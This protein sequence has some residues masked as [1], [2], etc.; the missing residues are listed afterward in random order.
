MAGAL[1]L[2]SG[3]FVP[4]VLAA[5]PLPETGR[6]LIS[7]EGDISLPA[8]EHADVVVVV[9]G[10]ADIRGEVNTLVVVQGTATLTGARLETV[11]AVRSE[12]E[13]A[14]GTVVY[15]ELQRLD[16][17]VHQTGNPQLQGGIVDLSARL[18]DVGR[19]VGPA[20]LM[21]WF[22]FALSTIVAGLLLAGLAARHVRAAEQLISREP[23]ASGATGLIAAIAIPIGAIL[24]FATVIGA[25][26]GFGILFVALPLVAFGGYLVIAT[27]LGDWILGRLAASTRPRERPYLAVVTGVIVLGAIGLVPVLGIV[28]AIASLFGFGAVILLALRTLTTGTSAVNGIGQ[29]MPAPTAA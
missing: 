13:V 23:V 25:P 27:W 19:F 11:V 4:A 24:L 28:V 18:V 26:L 9:N 1:I 20:L 22:G 29:P 16:S 6:V 12:V 2:G 21:L 8:G 17:A 15:G 5:G 3:L 7:T 10:K 14:A